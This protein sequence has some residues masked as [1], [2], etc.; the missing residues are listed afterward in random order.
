MSQPHQREAVLS[1][2]DQSTLLQTAGTFKVTASMLKQLSDFYLLGHMLKDTKHKHYRFLYLF[3]RLTLMEKCQ[4]QLLLP[5]T[6]E[7]MED[8]KETE[9]VEI[10]TLYSKLKGKYISTIVM[11][12]E[13]EL[14]RPN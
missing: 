2:V 12:I 14:V 9:I 7:D 13:A 11:E 3:Q 5:L 4:F 10:Y 8:F 6:L 1:L